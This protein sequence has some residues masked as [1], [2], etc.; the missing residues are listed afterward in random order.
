MYD[1]DMSVWVKVSTMYFEGPAAR[2]LQ[3]V[4]HRIHT[5]SWVEL[6]S[7]IH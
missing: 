7:W 1:A 5:A 6:C 3:S 2:W 4:D